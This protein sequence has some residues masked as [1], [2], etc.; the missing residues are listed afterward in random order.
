MFIAECCKDLRKK[1][2]KKEE[3]ETTTTTKKTNRI[4]GLGL[5]LTTS[6]A[7]L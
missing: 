3:N 6:V 4:P 5:E 2:N 7:V 1:N